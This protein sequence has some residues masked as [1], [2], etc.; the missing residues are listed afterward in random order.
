MT[1]QLQIRRRVFQ[2]LFFILFIVA[3]VL[4]IFRIDITRSQVIL[5]GHEWH[6][7]IAN[8]IDGTVSGMDGAIN[9]ILR[10]FIPVALF[11]FVF[12]LIA[13]RYGRLYCGWL[14][15]HFSVV[16]M[17]N[18][19]MRRASRR[20][21][22]WE[23][24]PLP[25]KNPDGSAIHTDRRYWWLAGLAIIGFAFLWALVLL[26][27]LLPPRDIYANLVTFSLTP[28]QIIFLAAATSVLSLEFLLARHLFCRF[29]CAVGVFQSLLWMANRRAMVVGFNRTRA[30]DCR[31]CDSQCEV[32]CPMRL[33]PRSNKRHMFTCTECGQ[34]LSACQQVQA[35]HEP[36][37][38]PLLQWVSG[39]CALDVSARDF[40]QRPVIPN[41][42]YQRPVQY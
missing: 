35:G 16:E 15:P 24:A 21:N 14:C 36:Q 1:K 2:A 17:I 9:L 13:W 19:L 12:G 33:K 18:G 23:K 41:N 27:Y 38:A 5:F 34:C 3:P 30:A 25:E 20:P 22:L 10:G 29:G 32:V 26:T 11:V 4:N 40:G 31:G 8:L 28:N 39:Q 7:G 6:L 37:Q 42:C